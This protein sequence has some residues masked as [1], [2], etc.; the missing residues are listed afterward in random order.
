[1]PSPKSPLILSQHADEH[2]SEGPV[3]LAVDQEIGEGTTLRVAPELADPLGSLEVREHED[4][5]KFGAGSRS[6]V[7]QALPEAALQ[8]VR[9]H[10]S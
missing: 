4:V 1:M 9:T 3:L 2:R 5:K 7:V 8:L 6:E 10:A